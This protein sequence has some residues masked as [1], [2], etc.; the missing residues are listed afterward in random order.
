M[1]TRIFK[2]QPGLYFRRT[3]SRSWLPVGYFYDKPVAP[4]VLVAKG[5][6]Y[7]NIPQ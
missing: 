1:M 4:D 2:T 5:K 7:L 6:E 3:V